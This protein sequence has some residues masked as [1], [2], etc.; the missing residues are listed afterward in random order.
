MVE[1]TRQGMDGPKT[2]SS[3][4]ILALFLRVDQSF[5]TTNI[6]IIVLISSVKHTKLVYVTFSYVLSNQILVNNV[7]CTKHITEFS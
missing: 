1:V 7:K 3:V 4:F 5:S 2:K 6:L